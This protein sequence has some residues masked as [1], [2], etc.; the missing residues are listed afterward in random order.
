MT[1]RVNRD[2]CYNLL[3]AVHSSIY[4]IL[5]ST[6]LSNSPGMPISKCRF[7][8][9]YERTNKPARGKIV[10]STSPVVKSFSLKSYFVQAYCKLFIWVI[11]NSVLLFIIVYHPTKL[12]GKSVIKS[13]CL[14]IIFI[15]RFFKVDTLFLCRFDRFIRIQNRYF[16]CS[17]QKLSQVP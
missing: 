11:V 15:L 4:A 12:S 16:Y 9:A 6:F 3:A 2:L 17:T 10:L 8:N 13:K 7:Y 1:T 14:S 5:I